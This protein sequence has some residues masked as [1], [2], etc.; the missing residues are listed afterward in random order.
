MNAARIYWVEAWTELRAGLRTPLV[1]LMFAG[2]IGYLFVMMTSAETLRGMGGAGVAR[3]SP[4]LVF[5][6][7]S[8]Q[9]FWLV[10]AWAWVFA[11]VVTR[12]RQA[13][14]HEL[15]LSAPV[16]LR[17]LLVARYAGALALA[18]LL[19]TSSAVGFWLA[20]LLAVFGV[21]PSDAIGPT[22]QLAIFWAWALFVVPTAA[23]LGALYLAAALRTR[24]T[25]GPFAA[26][27]VVILIWMVAMIVLR[28][29][30]VHADV[31][32]AIDAT[33]F[34]EAEAQTKHWTPI[35]KSSA[36]IALTPALLLNRVLW[37]MLPLALLAIVVSRQTREALVLER[38]TRP[39][40]KRARPWHPV[41][42]PGAP[43]ASGR[44]SWV[45]ATFYETRFILVRMITSWSFGIAAALWVLINVGGAFYHLIAHAEGPL[46]PRAELLAP[47]LINF[48][49]VFSIFAVAG[50]VGA[51]ARK[52][53]RLGFDEMLDAT[54]APFAVRVLGRAAAALA[55]TLTLALIPTLSA[56]I[57]IGIAAPSTFEPFAALS[58]NLLVAAPALLELGALTFLVHS[59]LRSSGAAYALS[60]LLAFIAI[61]NHEV[62]IVSY[63][64]GQFAIPVHIHLSELSG[65][66][67]WAGLVLE[68]TGLKLASVALAVALA[69]W[70]T[71]RGVIDRTIERWRQAARRARGAAGLFALIA[72][73]ALV[74]CTVRLHER[75]RVH[76]GFLSRAEEQ[77]Q[78]AAWEARYWREASPF[79]LRGGE[80]EARVDV[81]ARVIDVS[82]KLQGVRSKGE[83]L[84]G[85][86]R[87][88]MHVTSALV[89]GRRRDLVGTDDFFGL[90]LGDCASRGC[91]V[92]LQIRVMVPEWF[93]EHEAPW[94]GA[95]GAWVRAA[96]LLPKLGHDFERALRAPDVRRRAGLPAQPAALDPHSLAPALAVAPA[97]AWRWSLTF[98][99]AGVGTPASGSTGGP[100]D[101][102]VA[103]GPARGRWQ[104]RRAE[105]VSAWYGPTHDATAQQILEDIAQMRSCL[106]PRLGST[107]DVS[108]VVQAPRGAG[109]IRLHGGLLWVPEDR[110]WDLAATGVGR[111]MRRAAIAQALAARWLADRADLRVEPGSR[112]LTD[113]VAGWLALECVRARDGDE[114]WLA[115]LTR[116]S[117][118][119]AEG[120]GALDAPLIGL[121]NDGAAE[122]VGQYAPHATMAWAQALGTAE[123]LRVATGVADRVRT[124]LAIREALSVEAGQKVASSL[125][126]APSASDISTAMTDER[127]L[128]VRG[129]RFQWKDGGWR[130]TTRSFDVVQRFAGDTVP[131]RRLHVPAHPEAAG[132]FV[133]FDAAPSFERSPRDNAWMEGA[134]R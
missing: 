133:F 2:L 42:V 12:D 122:W 44:P 24:S 99:E 18:I 108:A 51:L 73:S 53:D 72:A 60:M 103:W 41:I 6:M 70:A 100:L 8:G 63:P 56:W 113:G 80:V 48:N 23:G 7:T 76:G 37:T 21:L 134:A 13:S 55:L 94:L 88:G 97:G 118:R 47:F 57:V 52:D 5:L 79:S 93:P 104:E 81:E 121:A 20:P 40:A 83:R 3:N 120:F 36:L 127:Q 49:F 124:G 110:G 96:D 59:L 106:D 34:G 77:G 117:E 14:L 95:S 58:I 11:Q 82:W 101:F 32:T 107:P 84:H 119:I 68:M 129:E 16:S 109:V 126:G 64:P 28:G 54:P 61:V 98:S 115:L 132:P 46:V 102:A 62:D 33:G 69:W 15:V 9:S 75:I 74:L 22:P 10:F 45:L 17:G 31:A 39:R 26:A 25:A 67:P 38:A 116:G 43:R 1:P 87:A 130:S 50:F 35:Q 91:D 111:F 89:D 92:A 29:G 131:S 112:W 105:G 114:A 90:D 78:D 65:W 86:L 128:E 27:A 125:L 4:L 19:G 30:S 71:P 66:S 123:A 85:S